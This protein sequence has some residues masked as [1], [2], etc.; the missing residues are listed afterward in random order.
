MYCVI[1]VLMVALQCHNMNDLC[2]VV[3]WCVL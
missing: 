1:S 2:R 3:T